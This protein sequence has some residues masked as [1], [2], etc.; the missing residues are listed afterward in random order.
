MYIEII[1]ENMKRPPG[2]Q[3]PPV[4][5]ELR[6]VNGSNIDKLKEIL[7][8]VITDCNKDKIKLGLMQNEPGKGKTTDECKECFS[9]YSNQIELVDIP[10]FVSE[11]LSIKENIELENIQIAS[12]YSG[13]LLEYM[14]QKFETIIDNEKQISHSQISKDITTSFSKPNFQKRI[15]EKLKNPKI[16]LSNF[17]I[18]NSPIIQSGGHYNT[19]ITCDNDNHNLSSDVIICKANAKYLEYHGSIIRTFMIDATKDQQ[20]KY[21]ILYESF[22]S[23]I[24]LLSEG[25]RLCDVYTAIKNEI[26][27]KDSSLESHIPLSFGTGIGLELNDETYQISSTNTKVIHSGMVFNVVLS[28]EGLMKGNDGKFV[29][30]LQIGDT[31]CVKANNNKDVYTGLI[32]KQLR[33]I[34]YDMEDDDDDDNASNKDGANDG[35]NNI[36]SG[37]SGNNNNNINKNNNY[38]TTREGN[39]RVTRHMNMQNDEKSKML[40]KR[41]EHQLELLDRKNDEFHDK[42]INHSSD[43]KVKVEETKINYSHIK[44]YDNISQFPP[45]LKQGKIYIDSRN[46][47]V[48][49]PIFNQMIPF[50]ISL[51]KNASKSEDN[52]YVILRINFV[53]PISGAAFGEL[54]GNN[55]VFIRDISYK[56][57]DIKY[58]SDLTLQI[59]DLG[60]AYKQK[61]QEHKEKSDLVQQEH[62]ILNKGKRIYLNEV[63]IRPNLT[64]KKTTG[65]LEAHTNGFKFI[66]NKGE[67]IEVIYKN[68]KHAF[69]QPC[70]NELITLVHFHLKSP[71]M[72]GKKKTE[73]VQFYKEVGVQAD[74]L[75]IRKRGN[76]YEEYEIELRERQMRERIND[77]FG[78]FAKNVE[79]IS[80]LEFDVPYRNMEFSGVPHRSNVTL[81]PT[82][83]CLVNL[84]EI[85][86][87]VI[88][89][90]E[91]NIVYFE[92]V[93]NN[94]KNFDMTFI[95]KDLS[96]PVPKLQAIPIEKL[97]MIKTWLDENDILFGEGLYN[98]HWPSILENIKED[99][100]GFLDLGGW[101][102][103]LDNPNSEPSDDGDNGDSNYEMNSEEE[104]EEDEENDDSDE[105]DY[106]DDSE[107][108]G[109]EELSEEGIDWDNEEDDEDED[110][111]KGKKRRKK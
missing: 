15:K 52:K 102:F 109:D 1:L 25:K 110:N 41:K 95:F 81:L 20:M 55:P 14:N 107:G 36:S 24:D 56:H 28:L 83:Y 59:R 43:L 67:K 72:V 98:M 29:Y 94:L 91:V 37:N 64:S 58:I 82:K 71:I 86:A 4:H 60:K 96:K 101:N 31:V 108:E 7:N 10:D 9:F 69:F 73:D 44:C 11:L 23:L 62:L 32:S 5:I 75:D 39:Q 49:L 90:S 45:D 6:N 18:E 2:I 33:D 70:E 26:I 74:D 79:D 97:D 47:T 89:L 16:E 12:R 8:V 30:M 54:K 57:R 65:V 38:K 93:S 104:E 99:P 35:N 66:S 48:F 3:C 34:Y 105:S 78:R 61:Q 111:R 42:I 53:V 76:D 80:I 100:Q 22:I 27:A 51:I 21:K 88:T 84:V 68:I 85:P 46:F 40:Q 13:L 87:F 103:I 19:S 106:D 63:T 50:H 77:E 17:E 92:R